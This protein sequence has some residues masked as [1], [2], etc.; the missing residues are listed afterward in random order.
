MKHVLLLWAC[1]FGPLIT[2]AQF[3]VSGRVTDA[4]SQKPLIGATVQIN[5]TGTT[6]NEQGYY[7]LQT[8]PAG[9]QKLVVSYLGYETGTIALNLQQDLTQ[10]VTLNPT[11]LRANEVVITATRANEKTGTT[12]TNVDKKQ[13]AERNFGQ[14]LPYLLEQT[15]SVVVN[16][17]AGA[18]VG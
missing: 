4:L 8:V 9:Q 16:S 11:S 1:L 5:Q 12:F 2:L 14:D 18:G 10:N 15:P 3:A 17:D 6:T 13:I 7:Q